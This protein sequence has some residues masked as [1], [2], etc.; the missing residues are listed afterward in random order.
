VIRLADAGKIPQ[1]FKLGALRRWDLS[2]IE[3]FIAAGC[4]IPKAMRKEVR[5]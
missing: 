1:G 3:Q 5:K 2:E 4:K